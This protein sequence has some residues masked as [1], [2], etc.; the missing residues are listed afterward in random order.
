MIIPLAC[1]VMRG[2]FSLA[3]LGEREAAYS[4]GSTK[5][6]MIRTV[7]L[8][9]G[10][11][12]IIGGTMLGLGRALGETVAVAL[13]IGQVFEIKFRVL[14]A[15]TNTISY[16]ISQRFSEA[17]SVQL[18]ALLTAGFVLFLLTLGVNTVAAVFVTRGRSG[19]GVEI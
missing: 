14:S 19:S 17:T 11:G 6:G 9:F 18:A 5:W 2:V 13:V 12:G 8:P 10:R 15:G 7:V 1:S 4:L 3:P 16:L